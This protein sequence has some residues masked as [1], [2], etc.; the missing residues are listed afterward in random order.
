MAKRDYYEVLG[1]GRDADPDEIKK[2]YRKLALKFHPD[3]NPGDREAEE[4][5][6]EATEAYEVLRD[7]ERRA[8]Y[9]RFGHE[10]PAMAGGGG[11]GGVGFEHFDLSEALRAFMR[12]F[13]GGG[14]FGGF[15]DIFGGGRGTQ[16]GRRRRTVS[17]GGNLEV[18]LPLTLEEIAR[19][20]TKKIRIRRWER[21]GVCGGSG[22]REGSEPVTCPTCEGAGQVQQVSRSMFGQMVN[23]TTCSN[24]KGEGTVIEDPCPNCS[25]AGRQQAQKTLSVKVPA[26]VSGG[27]YLTLSG[28][29]NVGMR[30]GPPGDVI[31]FLEEK[32]H[33]QFDREGDDLYRVEPIPFAIA[34]LGGSAEIPTLDGKA[35]VKIPA[36]TQS[37][38]ILRLRGKGLP[39]LHGYGEGDLLVE[40]VVWTPRKLSGEEKELLEQ[41]KGSAGF[42]PDAEVQKELQKARRARRGP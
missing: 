9:D 24:C 17:R 5:F 7:S 11:A 14:G 4:K 15:E 39:H 34:A 36:G 2:A 13:G 25:G 33:D 8:Q 26:G 30:G 12:D 40:V 37:G 22:A 27:N 20:V 35:R 28:E 42:Q 29:G 1:V 31:V 3:R 10:G 18:K 23:V 19:G 41:M 6:K 16:G 32:T 21:C 38:K